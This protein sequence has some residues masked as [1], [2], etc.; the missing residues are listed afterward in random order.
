M[1]YN[2]E[3]SGAR[4][5]FYWGEEM[6]NA[7]VEANGRNQIID[8]LKNL[9]ILL[10]HDVSSDHCGTSTSASFTMYIGPLS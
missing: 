1:T 10:L 9:K 3:Q 8:W 5:G 7:P 6:I 2:F 4:S